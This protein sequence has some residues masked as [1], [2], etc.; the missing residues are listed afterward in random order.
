MVDYQIDDSDGHVQYVFKLDDKLLDK[1]YKFCCRFSVLKD[2]SKSFIL[3][4]VDKLLKYYPK[5]PSSSLLN[6]NTFCLPKDDYYI[7]GLLI[8]GVNASYIS[9]NSLY[10]LN[11]DLTQ[12]RFFGKRVEYTIFGFI[13]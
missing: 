11:S 9:T 12:E 10:N 8:R 4:K 6:F 3:S 5:F 13:F 2:L 1:S 7:T